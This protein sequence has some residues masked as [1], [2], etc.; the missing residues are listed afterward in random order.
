MEWVLIR[1]F[2]FFDFF[3][4]RRGCILSAVLQVFPP[5]FYPAHLTVISEHSVELLGDSDEGGP[6]TELLQFSSPDIGASRAD[7]TED[8]SYGI[9]HRSFIQDLDCLAFW[10]PGDIKKTQWVNVAQIVTSETM[11]NS[12]SAFD[13]W[14][15]GSNRQRWCHIWESLDDQTFQFQ[16]WTLSGISEWNQTKS[17]T[18]TQPRLLRVSS[19]PCQSSF[20]RTACISCRFSR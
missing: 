13:P 11:W 7:T 19:W 1:V 17:L 8:V 3:S 4:P 9:L 16:P 18:C 20:R 5:T 10:R 14:S 2:S 12:P 15:W 6:A